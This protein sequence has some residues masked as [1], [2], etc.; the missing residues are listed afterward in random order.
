MYIL[1]MTALVECITN[2]CDLLKADAVMTFTA[3]SAITQ[4]KGILFK[5]DIDI[6]IE[7]STKTKKP[8]AIKILGCIIGLENKA[9][10]M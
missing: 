5:D 1:S 4:M 10:G 2:D 7:N 9:A 8:Y 6:A 3:N